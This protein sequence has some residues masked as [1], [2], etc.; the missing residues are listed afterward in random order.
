MERKELQKMLRGEDMGG[1]DK[2]TKKDED[3]PQIAN[4][5]SDE[6]SCLNYCTARS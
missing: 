2:K 6:A 1:K 4:A 3:T 5:V